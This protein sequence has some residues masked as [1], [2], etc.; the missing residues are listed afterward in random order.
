M[1]WAGITLIAIFGLGILSGAYEQGKLTGKE[2]K[3]S[4]KYPFMAALLGNGIMVWLM[5]LAGAF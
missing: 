2:K 3:P 1:N 5:Y 4:E